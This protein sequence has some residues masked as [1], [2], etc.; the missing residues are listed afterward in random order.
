MSAILREEAPDISESH[1]H[2]PP[3]LGRIVQHC[4]EKDASM[5]FQSARDLAFDLEAISG[6]SGSSASMRSRGIPARRWLPL[7]LA[8]LC[9]A[10]VTALGFALVRRNASGEAAA[11]ANARTVT[12]LTYQLGVES[13]PSLSPDGETF[14]YVS[15]ADGDPDIYFQRVDGFNPINLTKDNAGNDTMP[16]FSPDGKQIAFRSDRDGGGIF[17]MGATGE[18]VR[19]L[20]DFGY[21][22]SWSPDG[23]SIVVANEPVAFSPEGRTTDS[24]L[25]LVDVASGAKKQLTDV[26]SVQPAFSP[27]G[28]RIAFWG[29]SKGGQRDI[30]TV[31]A[32]G[33]ETP[34]AV[35]DDVPLDWNPVWSADGR[36]LYFGSNRDGTMN[37][38]RVPID[39]KSGKTLGA[40]EPM[41]LPGAR[42]GQFSISR[43]GTRL[44][45]SSLRETSRIHKMKFDPASG[46]VTPGEPPLLGGTMALVG[47]SVSADGQW[48]A[49]RLTTPTD[50]LIVMRADGSEIRRIT[51]DAY[52]D[53]GPKFPPDGKSLVFYAARGGFYQ[54]WSVRI[55]GSGLEQLTNLG[56]KDSVTL[57]TLS[58][59]GRF[60]A[61]WNESGIWLFDRTKPMANQ[62]PVTIPAGER[63][64]HKVIFAPLEWSGDSK[65]IVGSF[66]TN[67]GVPLPGIVICDVEKQSYETVHA[68]GTPMFWLRRSGYILVVYPDGKVTMLDPKLGTERPLVLPFKPEGA[69]ASNDDS[70]IVFYESEAQSDIWLSDEAPAAQPN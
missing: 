6:M 46:T 68:S 61:T 16:A 9:G 51:N 35:T 48:I 3:A 45:Y 33:A 12:Q 54:L 55:D 65:R 36:Y 11:M 15:A 60:I 47:P 30:R 49:A 66:R 22:P 69:S 8:L 57:P 42:T 37:L 29:V 21:N 20:S 64:G 58:P 28:L 32:N 23:R 10:A 50:D 31:A 44:L 67:D 4:L 39:E 5:R 56:E 27:N 17:V 59:D 25:W 70:T 52:R 18:S 40:P 1:P 2:L 43:S 63:D 38:W 62:K 41:R 7:A 24:H 34:V 19:R 14:V 13:F 53:R 26:D